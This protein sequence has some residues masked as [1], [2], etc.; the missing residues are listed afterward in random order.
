MPMHEP[1][2]DASTLD[3]AAR[4]LW[5]HWQAGTKLAALPAALQPGG[6]RAGYAVQACLPA[7]GGRQVVGWKIAATSAAGQAHIAVSGPIAGRLLSGQVDGD[8]ATQSLAGN[9]M[10]VV[11]PEFAF[12]F[13]RP[14]AP[15]TAPYTVAEVL[16]A[17]ATLHPAL[18]MPDSRFADFV[19]AGEAQLIADDACAHRLVLG[20]AAT[21]LWRE[22]D[23]REH[24]VQARVFASDACRLEREGIGRNVLGDP[25][26]ALAWLVNELSGLGIGL[27]AGQFVSTG[28]CATPLEVLPG[29]RVEVDYGALGR[30]SLRIAPEQLA[31]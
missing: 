4:T 5:A 19:R 25:R 8:G 3:T 9:G 13:G 2:P 29:D 31:G 20:A 23:L 24:R 27:Q 30:V 14:L 16:A 15:R 7:V 26:E 6:R 21:D 1:L 28:T 17:V 12:R 10:R 18:E 11:E 22:L